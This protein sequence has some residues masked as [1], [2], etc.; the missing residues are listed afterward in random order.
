LTGAASL[1]ARVR[2]GDRAALAR[3][4]SWIDDGAPDADAALALLAATPDASLP[5]PHVV[6]VTG[7]PGSGKSTLVEALLGAWLGRGERVAV[8]AVDPSSPITGG[9]VLG[10]RVRMGTNGAHANAFVRSFSARG[11]LGGLSRAARGA[12]AACAGAGFERIVV[13]TVGTGQSEVAIAALAETR[14]VV[15]PPGL[16]DEVQALKAG[17]LEIADLLVVSKGD[18]PLAER[19]A[20]D[21]REML[22]L[23][24]APAAG[25]WQPE[26][27]VVSATAASGLQALLDGI[28]AHRDASHREPE[29]RPARRLCRGQTPTSSSACA[30]WSSRTAS[31]GPSASSSS[32]AAPAA[33]RWP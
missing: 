22:H 10:D 3:L 5:R 30:G 9:A 12:V 1:A 27:L 28:D 11:E 16:G 8:L 31:A 13:E 7:I 23:R 21:L 32:R 4:L 19:T 25:T 29:S 24:R 15:T 17:T 26:V 14:I 2:G 33:P 6:G 18:L 20:R